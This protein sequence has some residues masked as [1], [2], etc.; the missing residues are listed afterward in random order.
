[1][2]LNLI[3][4]NN[5]TWTKHKRWKEKE[6]THEHEHDHLKHGLLNVGTHCEVLKKDLVELTMVAT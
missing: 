2:K 6:S 5:E 3:I 4:K 1:M